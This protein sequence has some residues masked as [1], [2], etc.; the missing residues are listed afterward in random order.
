MGQHRSLGVYAALPESARSFAFRSS[1]LAQGWRIGLER[2]AT[3]NAGRP[4]RG[5]C[6]GSGVIGPGPLAG[7]RKT[8]SAAIHPV[9]LSGEKLGTACVSP[10]VAGQSAAMA[11]A[12]TAEAPSA[13]VLRIVIPQSARATG[14]RRRPYLE[15]RS[16]GRAARDR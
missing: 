6:A 16:E 15:S 1:S 5:R 2:S 11:H 3:R 10:A 8:W 4:G 14:R 13:E 9:V 7:G 12:K